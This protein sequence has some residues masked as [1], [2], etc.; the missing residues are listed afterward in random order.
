MQGYRENYLKW[1]EHK[2][3]DPEMRNE[4][5]QIKNDDKEIRERFLKNLEFGTA[6]LRGILGAGTNR[7]NIY[8]I[9]KASQGLANYLKKAAQE[10]S[11]VIAYDTRHKSRE[12]ALQAAMVLAANDIKTYVFKEVTA[13]P[14]LSYAVTYLKTT[15]GIVITASH[16]PKEYNGYKVYWSHGGQ[17][18]DEMALSITREIA[19]LADELN[20]PVLEQ[21]EA[22]KQGLL[23]W[24]DDA[25]YNSYLARTKELLLRAEAIKKAADSLSI[26]YTP[27]HGTG[28]PAIPELLQTAGFK[29]FTVVSEQA[30]PDPD[31]ST[32]TYPNPEEPAAFELARK[33]AQAEAADLVMATDPDADRLGVLAKDENGHYRLL[34]GNQLG[35]LLI[36]YIL[37]ARKELGN[38]PDN[39]VII[40]TIVTS[41]LGADIARQYGIGFM[42]VLTGFKYIGEKIAE[43]CQNKRHTFLFGY[44]ES[45]GFLIGDFVRDKDAIQTCL[46]SAEMAAYHKTRG[47]TLFDRL[48]QIYRELGYYLDD[49]VNLNLAGLEGQEKINRIMETFRH[50]PP[51]RVNSLEINIFRDYLQGIEKIKADGKANFLSLPRANVLHYTLE[52]GSWFSIRPSGTEPKL[53]IYFSVKSKTEKEAHSKLE[54]IKSEI[55]EI[56]REI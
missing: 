26:V 45:Y 23:V 4:L 47:L 27:L 6:G 43:F 50:N 31:F 18:T 24:L 30:V 12:F 33:L 2:N 35:A 15:A 11:A 52:D 38:L 22:E 19:D 46:L 53:K 3:L 29:N 55:M 16:N 39:G 7:M 14:I 40:K 36:D 20:I 54:K 37:A 48:Q 49:L 10:K 25:V 42:E 9:R 13:T 32:I 44:E 41:S 1:L 5:E 17:I 8:T 51:L 28:C 21:K 34:T 56:I